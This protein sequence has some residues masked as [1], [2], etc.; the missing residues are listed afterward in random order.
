LK[1]LDDTLP[2][3][4]RMDHILTKRWESAATGSAPRIPKP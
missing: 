4:L 2:D 3:T 1:P